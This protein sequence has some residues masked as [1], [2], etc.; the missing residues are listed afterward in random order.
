MGQIVYKMAPKARIGFATANGGEVNFANNI[1]ALAALPGFEYPPEI[2]KGFKADVICD[3]VGYS[4]EPF[5][6]DGLIGNAVDDVAAFGVSY[7]SSAG[8]DI[9]TYDYDSDYR[10]VPNGPGALDGTNINL[11]GVPTNLYQGG[12]HNFNPNPGQQDVAQTVNVLASPPATNFQWDDPF[13]QV[14]NFDPNPIYHRPRCIH[15][16]GPDLRHAKSDRRTKLCHHRY[17]RRR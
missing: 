8:N 12:F 4:D 11:A 3:D 2:Q 13:N 1:R 15:E 6:Q 17:G 9:G 16:H 5:F 7:F 10:N 14:L